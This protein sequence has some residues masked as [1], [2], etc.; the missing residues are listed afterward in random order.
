MLYVGTLCCGERCIQTMMGTVEAVHLYRMKASRAT[1][2]KGAIEV[3]ID[4]QTH[5]SGICTAA[6]KMLTGCSNDLVSKARRL[7]DANESTSRAHALV[8]Y[9]SKVRLANVD[10]RVEKLVHR[11]LDEMTSGNPMSTTR[12][13][14]INRAMS[15]M[16]RRGLYRYYM[17]NGGVAV[18]ET[19]FHNMTNRWLRER[20]YDGGFDKRRIDHN[21]CPTCKTLCFK[22]DSVQMRIH[23]LASET[24]GVEI[25]V[26]GDVA[27]NA[28]GE[29]APTV[30]VLRR[31]LESVRSDMEEHRRSNAERRAQVQ[32]W[33]EQGKFADFVVTRRSSKYGGKLDQNLVSAPARNSNG[34]IYV[35]HVDGEAGRKIPTV[36]FETVGGGF[37]GI[38]IKN[39]QFENLSRPESHGYFLSLLH[40]KDNSNTLQNLIALD[41]MKTRGEEVYTMVMDTGPVNYNPS[42]WAF[43]VYIVDHLKWFRVVQLLFLLSRHGK[44]AADKVFG[45]H[46]ALHRNADILTEDHLAY[47]YESNRRDQCEEIFITEANS[48]VDFS[49]WLASRSNGL[50]GKNLDIRKNAYS[51]VVV[52]R[53]EFFASSKCAPEVVDALKPFLRPRGYYAMRV[54]TTEEI[55]DYCVLPSTLPKEYMTGKP[56]VSMQDVVV[57][58]G[59]EVTGVSAAPDAYAWPASRSSIVQSGYNNRNVQSARADVANVETFYGAPLVP[60]GYSEDQLVAR[61][62]NFTTRRHAVKDH[63]PERGLY[64]SVE[65][66]NMLLGR[67]LKNLSGVTFERHVPLGGR[68]LV[69]PVNDTHADYNLHVEFAASV[70][71][72]LGKLVTT[73]D[74]IEAITPW[75]SH[76]EIPEVCSLQ[77]ALHERYRGGVMRRA[78]RKPPV[79][80]FKDPM[81]ISKDIF[82]TFGK[83]WR[84]TM[85]M[86]QML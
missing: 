71:D 57:T 76:E 65:T 41:M 45:G 4:L 81:Q 62:R 29:E 82:E 18:K 32:F 22:A 16:G 49:S 6:C 51:Q 74:L 78:F 58:D 21:V 14:H 27:P 37:E 40:K 26:F 44:H 77:T 1:T 53:E 73:A 72:D 75:Y 25:P 3:L 48:F 84:V 2:Q 50:D 10:V 11:Y 70:K 9:R 36:R 61:P 46:R 60:P 64:P 42:L 33:V 17:A 5:Y 31:E 80:A 38:R 15:I 85:N 13:C 23:L 52:V 54:G 34:G 56:P 69:E 8:L 43:F 66:L 7:R 39:I 55:H 28:E 68:F 79:G 86:N 24:S 59:D 30:E 83:D 47:T 35:A 12:R 63:A 19:T 20:G 67:S